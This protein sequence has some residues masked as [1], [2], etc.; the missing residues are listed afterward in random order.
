MGG[1]ELGIGRVED[2]DPYGVV[3]L[4]LAAEAVELDDE[5]EVEQVD[6]RMVDRRPGDSPLDADPERLVVVVGHAVAM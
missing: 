5:R 1:E 2:H 6:R 3:G 4:D